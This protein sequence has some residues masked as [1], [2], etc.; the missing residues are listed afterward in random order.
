MKNYTTNWKQ[1]ARMEN[2]K[3]PEQINVNTHRERDAEEDH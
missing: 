1:H 3:I 2:S